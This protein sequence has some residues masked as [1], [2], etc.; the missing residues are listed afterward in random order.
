[1]SK[2][3][4]DETAPIRY[5][6]LPTL[7][8]PVRLQ[9]APGTKLAEWQAAGNRISDEDVVEQLPSRVHEQDQPGWMIDPPAELRPPSEH[10]RKPLHWL[11]PPEGRPEPWAWNTDDR[12]G[13]WWSSIAYE[14]VYRDLPGYR[15]LGPA[16]WREPEA[17]PL[18]DCFTQLQNAYHKLVAAIDGPKGYKVQ[19]GDATVRIGALRVQYEAA[20]NA[21]MRHCARI[22]ELEAERDAHVTAMA[23]DGPKADYHGPDDP[24]HRAVHDVAE[25]LLNGRVTNAKARAGLRD[26]LDKADRPAEGRTKSDQS[27]GRAIRLEGPG[28]RF[29]PIKNRT[30]GVPVD[31]NALRVPPPPTP[32]SSPKPPLPATALNP[33][34]VKTGLFVP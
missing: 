18:A 16:E 27:L 6:G 23:D 20:A 2:A 32:K 13:Q 10:A 17:F 31:A 3:P 25:H 33:G 1:M 19:I 14:N 4:D 12:L 34:K 28:H 24:A 5:L 29:D 30:Y 9:P 22:T 21:C 8:P 11:Q 15:Y 7:R 26:A